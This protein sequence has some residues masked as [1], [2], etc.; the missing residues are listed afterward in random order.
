M[1]DPFL[2]P[3]LGGNGSEER[4]VAQQALK[5]GAEEAGERPHRQ[6]EIGGGGDPASLRHAAA[7]DEV[8]NVGMEEKVARPGVKDADHADLNSETAWVTRQGLGGFG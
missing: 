8:V 6:E 3:D 1:D 5:T 2:R 4:R 7:W